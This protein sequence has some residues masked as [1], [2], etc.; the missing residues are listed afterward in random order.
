VRSSATHARSCD[1][2][3]TPAPP[4]PMVRAMAMEARP[5]AVRLT[6]AAR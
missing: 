4:V 3:F 5:R 1:T 2:E 6:R